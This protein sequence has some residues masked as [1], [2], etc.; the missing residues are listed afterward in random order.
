MRIFQ[1]FHPLFLKSSGNK[2]VVASSFPEGMLVIIR[3]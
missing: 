1:G 2:V 3:L